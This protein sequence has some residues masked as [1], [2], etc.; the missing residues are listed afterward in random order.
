MRISKKL[1][2]ECSALVAAICLSTGMTPAHAQT[3]A[4]NQDQHS[5]SSNDSSD[6]ATA[7]KGG[8]TGN[9]AILQEL[10]AMRARIQE[11]EA[12]LKA[13]SSMKGNA[14]PADAAAQLQAFRRF[15]FDCRTGSGLSY[16]ANCR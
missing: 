7:V 1:K 14:M 4:V 11:L 16:N 5:V 3:A 10:E 13:Q 15:R 9:D 6:D 8:G 2:T 12:Q